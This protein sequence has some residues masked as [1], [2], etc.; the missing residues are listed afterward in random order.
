MTMQISVA[1]AEA[2]PAFACRDKLTRWV[3]ALCWS[4]A[5]TAHAQTTGDYNLVL[6]ESQGLQSTISLSYVEGDRTSSQ[7]R[8]STV[9]GNCS[10]TLTAT[11][12]TVDGDLIFQE[13]LEAGRCK[14]D[15]KL[16]L[17]KDFTQFMPICGGIRSKARTLDQVIVGADLIAR[18]IA[19]D[20][21][22]ADRKEAQQQ[23]REAASR[24]PC[25]GCNIVQEGLL[26]AELVGKT[27]Y[28][29]DKSKF[30]AVTIT[31]INRRMRSV[32]WRDDAS[33]KAG[34]NDA[35]AYHT[36]VSK[37]QIEMTQ[38]LLRAGPTA[39]I[40]TVKQPPAQ[41][42]DG[43]STVAYPS[44][45]AARQGAELDAWDRKPALTRIGGRTF[46]EQ[47]GVNA[48]DLMRALASS[49]IDSRS[50]RVSSVFAG[51]LK[52]DRKSDGRAYL[53]GFCSAGRPWCTDQANVAEAVL[54][55]NVYPGDGKH[56]HGSWTLRM[57]MMNQTG[58]GAPPSFCAAADRGAAFQCVNGRP[59][60]FEWKENLPLTL[61][62][63]PGFASNTGHWIR[64]GYSSVSGSNAFVEGLAGG[65]FR[66]AQSSGQTDRDRTQSERDR[67]ADA[68]AREK[69]GRD[70][71][72]YPYD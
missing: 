37:Q 56:P 42:I 3:A 18:V 14:K 41:A 55:L 51:P 7:G 26:S 30:Y 49:G 21:V 35:S 38:R 4:A 19:A 12:R 5:A 60:P 57:W 8:F 65:K 53:V 28:E 46:L 50:L 31:G 48:A 45:E 16:V 72:Q 15:C 39:P 27:L 20:K 54:G 62:D 25:W 47:A 69:P 1:P 32:N 2:H 70:A 66:D 6:A 34:T 40:P 23:Q 43:W 64:S 11:G 29:R 68:W 52:L 24:V 71:S 59:Y 44:A 10:G 13:R 36:E 22:V 58:D 9:S 33:G 67:R 17:A 63:I 61:R